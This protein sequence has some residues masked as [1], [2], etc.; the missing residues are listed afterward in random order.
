MALGTGGNMGGGGTHTDNVTLLFSFQFM[1]NL[2]SRES[3]NIHQL[4]FV[5]FLAAKINVLI[6]YN[7][8]NKN[9]I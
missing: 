1:F 4:T 6:P 2:C 7:Y 3:R 9:F 5:K 8:L